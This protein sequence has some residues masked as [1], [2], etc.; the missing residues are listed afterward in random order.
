MWPHIIRRP[1]SG[2]RGYRCIE[3]FG[4]RN[5]AC[6]VSSNIGALFLLSRVIVDLHDR[7][8]RI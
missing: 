8:T 2:V 7:I 3:L 6:R 5:E 4:L 1:G